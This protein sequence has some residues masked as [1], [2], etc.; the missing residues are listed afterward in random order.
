M[1]AGYFITG[2]DTN[3]GKT[4]VASALV[5]KFAQDGFR[6]IG[7]KP[8]A[9][10]CEVV[11]GKF[12]SE[13]AA[14]LIAASNVSAS[15]EQINPYAFQPPIAPHIASIQA[16]I[17]IKLDT[18]R[19]AYAALTELADI[20]VVEGAGGFYVPLSD[21]QDI[22]A[23]AKALNLHVILVVGMRLGCL[24]HALLT[25]EAI[26]ARGLRLAGWVA[27]TVDPDMAI[28]EENIA[29]LKQRI[30]APCLGVIPWQVSVDFKAAAGYLS[31]AE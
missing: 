9:A 17:E 7:M 27:N 26:C 25:A 20:V 30:Q 23:L 5:Y 28:F 8:V 4:L 24:N 14:Q 15:L 18:I 31:Y 6:A 10:G 16:G 3:V 22:A 1:K 29:S 21:S 11:E 13:D 12:L 2:T 19:Q